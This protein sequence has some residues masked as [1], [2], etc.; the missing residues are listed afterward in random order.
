MVQVP[1]GEIGAGSLGLR[2]GSDSKR[3]KC[4]AEFGT[5]R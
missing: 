4:E 2:E 1:H 5:G 3:T